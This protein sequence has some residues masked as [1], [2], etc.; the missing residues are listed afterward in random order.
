MGVC[1]AGVIPGLRHARPKPHC[2]ARATGAR[3]GFM[4]SLR[5]PARAA[6]NATCFIA[7]RDPRG[8]GPVPAWSAARS[9]VLRM[10]RNALVVSTCLRSVR[11]RNGSSRCRVHA[12]GDSSIRSA[13]RRQWRHRGCCTTANARN[14]SAEAQPAANTAASWQ[15]DA[16]GPHHPAR[17]GTPAARSPA[18][19]GLHVPC[20]YRA[21]GT[22]ADGRLTASVRP[23]SRP[24]RLA[25][26]PWSR[27]PFQVRRTWR[28]RCPCRR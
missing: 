11:A 13:S 20:R 12:G 6:M 22:V 21:A 17:R 26:S 7:R 25:I 24:D 27:R 4:P 14:P 23:A 19:T 5:P 28:R 15:Q 8:T 9:G 3:T 18:Q 10:T 1:A 16:A 2:S